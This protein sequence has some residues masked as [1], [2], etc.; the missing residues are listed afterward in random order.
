MTSQLLQRVIVPVANEDDA[1]TTCEA[2]KHHLDEEARIHLVHVI[3]K[4]G[5]AP[6]KAPLGA[7]QKQATETFELAEAVL[8]P[9][10]YEFQTEVRYGTDVVDEIVAAV[11]EHR[12]TA[13][14]FLPREGGRITKYLT[15]NKTR[16]LVATDRVP[17]IALPNESTYSNN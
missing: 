4:G 1:R 16:S 17:V 11:D 3:E 12:A 2:V 10:G 5:G 7:R 6:D 8:E 14:A 15:G 9:A 13:I